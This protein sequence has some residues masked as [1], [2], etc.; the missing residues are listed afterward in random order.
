MTKLQNFL[1][2]YF[3]F[4]AGFSELD[5]LLEDF[6]KEPISS[7]LEFINELKLIIDTKNFA[8]TA[9]VI[10]RYGRRRFDIETTEKFINYLYD[11]L[12]DRPTGFKAVDFIK[13]RKIIFCPV[14]TPHPKLAIIAS[15][16]DKATVIANNIEIYICKPCK[17]VWLDEN[18]IRADNAVGYKE[19][20]KAN[21]LK[22][23]WNEL[24]D[25]DVL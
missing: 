25:I 13:K 11:V 8:K 22:G 20:M 1:I 10:K 21:G 15:L 14:C 16:I 17:L 24:K 3:H 5:E 6:K 19:F 18:D 2:C 4:N 7:Q 23:F 9:R 12:L